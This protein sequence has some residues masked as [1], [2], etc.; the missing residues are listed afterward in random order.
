MGVSFIFKAGEGG[1]HASWG[2]GINFDGGGGVRFKKSWDGGG[3][4]H[5]PPLSETL[6]STKEKH[7]S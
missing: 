1:G 6:L 4:P 3:V 5:V 7:Q 2:R